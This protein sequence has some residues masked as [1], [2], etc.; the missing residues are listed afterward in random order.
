VAVLFGPGACGT[1]A[2]INFV[3]LGQSAYLIPSLVVGW[4]LFLLECWLLVFVLPEAFA[5]PAGVVLNVAVGLGFLVSQER[6]FAAWKE[7]NW[8]PAQKGEPYRP[9]GGLFLLL[10]VCLGCLAIELAILLPLFLF[11]G[12]V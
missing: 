9:T 6:A 11:F 7:S 12:R 5:R 10:G 3:R 8:A 1:V 4:A 2:G